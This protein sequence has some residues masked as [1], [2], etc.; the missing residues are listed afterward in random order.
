MM[1]KVLIY[2]I[3]MILFLPCKAQKIDRETIQ[4]TFY[5]RNKDRDFSSSYTLELHS[6]GSFLLIEKLFEANPQ[7]KGK[8]ELE[9]NKFIVL[10]C[11]DVNDVVETVTNGYMNKREQKLLIISRN[12]IRYNDVILKRR[13]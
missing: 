7:C 10:K 2:S 3:A 13:R 6:D 8:W 9:D 12:K 11:N 4:G 1:K 5:R